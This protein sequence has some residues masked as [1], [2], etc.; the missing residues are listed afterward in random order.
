MQATVNRL[1]FTDDPFL[2]T[3]TFTFSFGSLSVTLIH[4]A[5]LMGVLSTI[6]LP[7]RNFPNSTDAPRPVN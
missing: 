7:S 4:S 3:T 2:M 5:E 1:S 6:T